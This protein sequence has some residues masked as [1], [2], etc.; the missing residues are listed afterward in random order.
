MVEKIITIPSL[1]VN[2]FDDAKKNS[3]AFF[4]HYKMPWIVNY[5]D[6]KTLSKIENTIVPSGQIWVYIAKCIMQGMRMVY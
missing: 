3:A 4:C 1:A 2:I 5:S 6:A